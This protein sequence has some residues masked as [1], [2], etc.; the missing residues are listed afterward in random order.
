MFHI[1]DLRELA[2][3]AGGSKTVNFFDHFL[4]ERAN[5]VVKLKS[6]FFRTNFIKDKIKLHS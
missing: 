5:E 4:M 6:V 2:M 3:L 1:L